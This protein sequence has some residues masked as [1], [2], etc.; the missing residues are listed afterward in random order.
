MRFELFDFNVK[1]VC[2]ITH[3]ISSVPQAEMAGQM[4]PTNSLKKL[5]I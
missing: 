2:M 3:W 4:L 5:N 1:Y